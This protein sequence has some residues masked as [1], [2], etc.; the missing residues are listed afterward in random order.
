M[1]EQRIIA[2]PRGNFVL[3]PELPEDDPFLFRLFAA[4]NLQTLRLAG[5]PADFIDK[6]IAFQHRS[7]TATYRGM[8]PNAVYSIVEFDGEAVGRFIEHDETDVVYFV[9]FVLFPEHQAKGL[10]SALTRALMQEWATKGRGTRVKILINNEASLTMCHKLGFV[11]SGPA[12]GAYVEL[13]WYPPA[14]RTTSRTTA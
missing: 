14:G 1:S 4:N 12:E 7:Q 9:D 3:R 11:E 8:F 5:F 2:T 13:R 10:G 6:L